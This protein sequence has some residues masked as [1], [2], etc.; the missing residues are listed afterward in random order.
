M[1]RPG[2]TTTSTTLV[3]IL[4]GPCARGG[5]SELCGSDGHEVA[6]VAHQDDGPREEPEP[7][8]EHQVPGPVLGAGLHLG[9]PPGPK[10]GAPPHA[11]PR[12]DADS[13]LLSLV[14]H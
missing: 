9:G 7:P 10:G 14:S 8:E 1:A 11:L 12:T 3:P 6:E 13:T 4:L 5:P 2:A